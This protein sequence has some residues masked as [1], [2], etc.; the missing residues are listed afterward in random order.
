MD[1]K[2]ENFYKNDLILNHFNI[3][4]IKNEFIIRHWKKFM[5]GKI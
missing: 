3:K 2:Y 5:V 1:S 4:N